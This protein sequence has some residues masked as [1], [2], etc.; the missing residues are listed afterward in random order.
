M[1]TGAGARSDNASNIPPTHASIPS[2]AFSFGDFLGAGIERQ[3]EEGAGGKVV[4]SA[5]TQI[6]EIGWSS[7][8]VWVL[9]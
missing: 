4:C 7:R 3:G 6:A 8:Y 9:G 2:F 1:V 5:W